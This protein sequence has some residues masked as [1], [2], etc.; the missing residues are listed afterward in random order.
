MAG[1]GR[2]KLG[3]ICMNRRISFARFGA[4]NVRFEPSAQKKVAQILASTIVSLAA[5][6]AGGALIAVARRRS[7][8]ASAIT[9]SILNQV[10]PQ[11]CR[12]INNT[13]ESHSSDGS[14]QASLYIKMTFFRWVNTVVRLQTNMFDAMWF[15]K[16]DVVPLSPDH[17]HSHPSV[18]G[19]LDR[20]QKLSRKLG[21]CHF[22][23][24]AS[25]LAYLC[26]V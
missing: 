11:V 7:A 5:V 15:R 1:L 14:R 17:Y 10:T 24:R 12:Y 16:P 22:L 25:H 20:R 4:A 3:K 18:L 8:V 21:L 2:S 9:I 19:F 6:A 26:P 13:F 23:L